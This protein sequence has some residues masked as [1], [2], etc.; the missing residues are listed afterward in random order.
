[1]TIRL[2]LV[3]HGR[4]GRIIARTLQPFD[5][6]S[7]KI[8]AK[9]EAPPPD[10]DGVIIANQSA[11][12]AQAALPYIAKGIATFIEKPMATNVTDAENI[13]DTAMRSGAGVFVGHIFLHHPAFVAALRLLPS[14]GAVR[15]ILGEGMNGRP[16][17]DTSVLWDHLPH[18]LSMAR[19]IFGCDPRSVTA[20]TL[21]GG[22]LPQAALSIFDYGDVPLVSTASWL[23]AVPR[24]PLTVVSEEATLVFDDKASR[25]LIIC[26]REGIRPVPDYSD[27]LPLTAEMKAFLE[28]VRGRRPDTA[29]IDLG[30]AVVRAIA[31][32]ERSIELGGQ[33]VQI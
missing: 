2:G 4:W 1:M 24:R 3:G 28:A 27:E 13:R 23:S 16:R 32:A 31:A 8:I 21:S 5:D 25:K 10:L 19:A 26:D 12:H 9:G 33:T 29:E 22:A 14:F 11:V 6:V 20:R 18:D 30:L 17:T 15:Y 7:L